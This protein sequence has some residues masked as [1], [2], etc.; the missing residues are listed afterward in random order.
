MLN[1]NNFCQVI[2]ELAKNEYMNVI[3]GVGEPASRKVTLQFES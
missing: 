2:K 1:I 3:R